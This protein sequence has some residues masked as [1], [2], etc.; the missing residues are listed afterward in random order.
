MIAALTMIWMMFARIMLLMIL[1]M[2]TMVLVILVCDNV[3]FGDAGGSDSGC[4][5]VD[6]DCVHDDVGNHRVD[7]D[8]AAF[9]GVNDDDNVFDLSRQ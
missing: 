7:Y 9:Y 1:V 8:F 3:D 6:N 2:E 4:D 5:D